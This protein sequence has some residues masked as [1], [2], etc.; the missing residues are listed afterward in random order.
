[1]KISAAFG[2]N[3]GLMASSATAG[4]FRRADDTE[5]FQLYGYGAGVGGLTLFYSGGN[6]YI[7]DYTRINNSDAA[8]VIFT[9]SDGYFLGSPNATAF[10]DPDDVP[11]GWEGTSLVIPAASSSSHAVGFSNSTTG[12]SSIVADSFTTYG[13]Y[14]LVSGDDG[15]MQSLWYTVPS[16]TRGVYAL[17]WNS[18]GE[19]E[20][21]TISLTLKKTPPSNRPLH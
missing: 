7:G 3:V 16:D 21:T 1:M 11:T 19:N 8:P 5:G 4:S 14:I 18:T 15:S 12:N 2:F 17:K 9:A 6:A 13:A 20:N 10:S